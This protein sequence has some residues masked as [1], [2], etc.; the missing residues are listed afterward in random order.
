MGVKELWLVSA[1]LAWAYFCVDGCIQVL[2]RASDELSLLE[3]AYNEGFHAPK[4]GDGHAPNLLKVGVDARHVI[5]NAYLCC[6]LIVCST[7]MHSVCPV[8]QHNHGGAGLSPELRTLF[9]QLAAILAMLIHAFFIFDG[10]ARPNL[11]CSACVHKRS[12]WLVCPFQELLNAFGFS[13]CKVSTVVWYLVAFPAHSCLRLLAKLK[14]S[15]LLSINRIS[16][17]W[18]SQQI[19]MLS[20]LAWHALLAGMSFVS[21]PHGNQLRM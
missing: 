19:V 14:L 13:W 3:F 12:H 17:T 9:Y 5:L 16:L 21:M 7:W 1:T 15:L 18:C 10:H 20:C 2:S 8:F 11:K 6:V 4:E